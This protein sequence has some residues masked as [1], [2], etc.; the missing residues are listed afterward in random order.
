MQQIGAGQDGGFAY[1]EML[2]GNDARVAEFFARRD[3]G[4]RLDMRGG[5]D[6][7]VKPVITRRDKPVRHQGKS[8]LGMGMGDKR[9]VRMGRVPLPCRRRPDNDAAMA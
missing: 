7:G 3:D 6:G 2:A 4:A 5:V 1:V 9:A 8:R